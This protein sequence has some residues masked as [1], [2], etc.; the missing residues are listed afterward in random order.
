M[1]AWI[2]SPGPHGLGA[3][4]AHFD[5][6]RVFCGTYKPSHLVAKVFAKNHPLNAAGVAALTS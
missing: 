6:Q 3:S 2:R 1:V 5:A 4:Q